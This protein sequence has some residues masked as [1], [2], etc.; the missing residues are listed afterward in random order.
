[1]F[2]SLLRMQLLN[3][4]KIGGFLRYLPQ[5]MRLFSRLF[6]DHRVS[7]VA[8]AVPILG[9]MMLFSPPLVELDFIPFLGEIDFLLMAYFTLKL[10]LWLCPQDVVR[11]HVNRIAQGA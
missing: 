8:K 3:P 9:L 5:F 2:T 6:F 7:W 11:E 10:F 4:L 1:M